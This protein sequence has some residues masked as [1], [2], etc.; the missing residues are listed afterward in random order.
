MLKSAQFRFRS[1][2]LSKCAVFLL[3]LIYCGS[4][5]FMSSLTFISRYQKTNLIRP[6]G[7]HPILCVQTEEWTRGLSTKS[8][9]KQKNPAEVGHRLWALNWI[10]PC[11][12]DVYVQHMHVFEVVL[13]VWVVK[14]RLLLPRCVKY[15]ALLLNVA[16]SFFCRFASSVNDCSI[17]FSVVI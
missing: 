9:N 4:C 8:N 11:V 16:S 6:F 12:R 10:V 2:F 15:T 3:H 17:S 14:A 1:F 5:G 13:R 7:I